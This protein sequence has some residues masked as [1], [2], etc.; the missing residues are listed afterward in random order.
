MLMFGKEESFFNARKPK[1]SWKKVNMF[2]IEGL[3]KK[4]QKLGTESEFYSKEKDF[5]EEIVT[6]KFYDLMVSNYQRFIF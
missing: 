6:K 5:F 3:E 4:Q 2:V 1:K